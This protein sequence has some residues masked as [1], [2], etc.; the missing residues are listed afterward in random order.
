MIST[1][2]T[3]GLAGAALCILAV[4]GCSSP[5]NSDSKDKDSAA[6]GGGGSSDGAT[7][8]VE[9]IDPDDVIVKQD[10]KVPGPNE[11]T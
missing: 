6:D 11:D 2:L 10:V 7:P 5:Q 8:G 4:T 1:K 9:N 3:R